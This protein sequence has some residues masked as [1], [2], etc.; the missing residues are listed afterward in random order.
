MS[1]NVLNKSH[2]SLKGFQSGRS[3]KNVVQA[4]EMIYKFLLKLVNEKTPEETLQE[5]QYLFFDYHSHPENVKA[6]QE[7]SDILLQ[8]DYEIFSNTLKRCCYILI[9]N[10]ETKRNHACIQELVLSF[11][12]VD[13]EKKFKSQMILRL[14]RWLKKF[15]NGKHYQDLKLYIKKYDKSNSSSS[16]EDKHHWSN[17]YVSYLLVPQYANT[18]NP[19]EQRKAARELSQKLKDRFKFDLAMYT[20]RS[21]SIVCQKKMPENPTGLGEEV[22]RLIK[23]IVA[24]RGNFS[25]TNLANI[26]LK[27]VEEISYENFKEALGN[28]LVFSV[29]TQE[30]VEGLQ[31]KIA[32]RLQ[33]IYPEHN[34]EILDDA[35]L[36]R[37][38]NRVL[39]CLTTETGQE[40]SDIFL[41]LIFQ[42]NPLT[43]VIVLLK[44][45][46]VSPHSRVHLEKRIAELIKHYMELSE[47]ECQWVVNFFE[48]FKITFAI[49]AD[50][51]VHYN[52]IK[53]KDWVPEN[54]SEEAMLDAYRIFS[55]Y[56]GYLGSILSEGST[57]P[58]KTG[59]V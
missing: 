4:Q 27:Q 43:L 58:F 55:Q 1:S 35:L 53:M 47:E 30:L 11:A 6:L 37:T 20:A 57:L 41:Y 23:K 38:C 36:L 56:R 3:R 40:P 52:L 26:F 28:Y 45:I 42:G 15:F 54:D 5:F 17:R 32:Q 16:S 34:D 44:L 50:N 19:K 33:S 12:S 9:N 2:Y 29:E 51:D 59:S 8:R 25:Y 46:L 39:D 31:N 48:I 24:K 49:Y 22:L 18:N 13:F 10:W 21:Q 14:R 7:L